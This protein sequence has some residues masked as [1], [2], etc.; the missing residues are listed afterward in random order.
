MRS[1]G[2]LTARAFW[3][4]RRSDGFEAASGPPD[5]TAMV[6]SLAMRANCFAMR[7]HRANIVCL[8]TSKM[9]PMTVIVA[10]RGARLSA[11]RVACRKRRR[12]FRPIQL[13]E[14]CLQQA[15]APALPAEGALDLVQLALQVGLPPVLDDRAALLFEPL[16]FDA[17]PVGERGEESLVLVRDARPQLLDLRVAGPGQIG[18][19]PLGA[20][21][22]HGEQ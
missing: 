11:G 10:R 12:R 7:F 22:L 1:L 18:Q 8:R 20:L 6:M 15:H 13:H 14:L 5:L 21:E 17:R 9:R 4:I 3:M 16:L 19:A 2:M